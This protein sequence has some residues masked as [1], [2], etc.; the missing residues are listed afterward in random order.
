MSQQTVSSGRS[1][2]SRHFIAGL[3]SGV[4]S[5]VLL[6]P[7]DLL[8]T[9]VQQSGHRSLSSYLKDVAAAPNKIQTLWR[10]T[11]PST[12]RTGFGSALY[13]TTLNSIRQYV[14]QSRLLGQAAASQAVH[15]SSLPT[16]TP[17]ANLVA[18]SVARTF[19]GF[20][21]MP[22]TVIKV[23]YESNLYSYQSLLGASSDIYRTNGLRGF[24]AGFGATAVR[25]A[26]YAGMYVLF[27]ELLKK[28][29]SG[30]SFDNGGQNSTHPT[31]IKTSHA[32]L[33]NFSSAIMAGAACSVVSNPFDAVKTRIQLQPAIY[34]NMYQA[35]HKMV[36]EEGVRSLLDGVALRMSR[37]AMSSALAWTVYEE[38]IRR[39]ERTWSS[40]LTTTAA[41][42]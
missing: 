42:P 24:F 23:R 28:R 13:F 6:Q 29:L 19:A 21:L 34:R 40:T 12:L 26:P 25:D 41:E 38:L 5:A 36:T 20:V 11:V 30:L 31:T 7:L 33:V 14:A 1:K 22:L 35:C 4:T 37:K 16:L 27:Y 2:S 10:G 18:G 9:R 32:T 8:K 15:S 3:G 17:T 39:A